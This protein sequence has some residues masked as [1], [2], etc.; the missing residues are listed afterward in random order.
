MWE[1]DNTADGHYHDD[2]EYKRLLSLFFKCLYAAPNTKTDTNSET[3]M[4][5]GFGFVRDRFMNPA[6]CERNLII[7]ANKARVQYC[8]VLTPNVTDRK[9]TRPCIT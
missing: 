5:R 2:D 8:S 9:L 7:L 4:G 3:K 6:H 1:E